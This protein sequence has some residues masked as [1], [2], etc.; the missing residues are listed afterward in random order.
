VIFFTHPGLED[1]R[2]VT[3]EMRVGA[4]PGPELVGRVL[5]SVEEAL[6]ERGAAAFGEAAPE[7]EP[8][9]FDTL[10]SWTEGH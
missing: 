5:R 1:D 3:R 6:R 4:L 10:G 9:T 7:R 8:F 2:E